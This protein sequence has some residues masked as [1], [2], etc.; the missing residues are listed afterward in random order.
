MSTSIYPPAASSPEELRALLAQ[1][2]RKAAGRSHSTPL[3]SAQQRLWFLDQLEPNSPRYNIPCVARLKGPLQLEPLQEALQTIVNRHESLRA[4]F[5]STEGAPVQIIDEEVR[6]PLHQQEVAGR[7]PEEQQTALERLIHQEVNRPFQLGHERLLRATLLRLHPQEHVLI[8]NMHHIISD[9]WSLKVLFQELATLY[10][11]RVEGRPA[12]LPELPIQYGDYAR[13]QQQWLQ[14]PG[15]ARQLQFWVD[16]LHGHPPTLE[17]PT[18]RPRRSSPRFHG[19]GWWRALGP[20]LSGAL[21]EL[22]GRQRVTLFMVLL[23]GFKALLYRY[24]RQED[25]VVGSPFAGRNRVETEDLI[26]FFVNT[27]PLR[28]RLS[29]ELSFEQLLAQI[30]EVALGAYSH[31]EVPFDKMVEA[32]H[33]ERSLSQTPF[34]NVMFLM[35][36]PLEE[37]GLPQLKLEFIDTGTETSKFDLTLGVQETGEGMIAGVEYSTDLFDQ[38]TMERLLQHYESVLQAMIANPQQRLGEFPL[39]SEQ[40]RRELIINSDLPQEESLRWESVPQWFESQATK[41]P[42]ATAVTYEKSSLTYE[43]LN[44]KA[45]QLARYLRRLGVKAETPVA[46]HLDRSLNLVIAI[47]GVLKAGGAYVPM[48]PAYPKE[49]LKFMLEDTQAPVLL[50]LDSLRATLPDNTARLVCLDSEW[51]KIAAED[52]N[53]LEHEVSRENG[54]Y[55]IYTSGSTGKPKGVVVTHRN[56][57][58]LFEQTEPWY[59]F[60]D[61]DVWTLFHSHT[62]DFSVWELWGAL[63]YGGRLVVVPYL[64]SRSP[65]EFYDLLAEERVTVLNQTPSAFRQLLW[66]EAAKPQ[67]QALNLRYV[68]FGGEALELQSLKP[69]FERHGDEKPRLVNM[70]GITE[71][72]VHV[73]YRIISQ[74]DL[75]SGLGSV[76]GVPIPDLRIYLLDERLEPV[77]PGVPGEICV[78]GSG[79]ARGYLNRPE[80]NSQRFVPDPFS[81]REGTRM[82]RSGDLAKYTASGELEYLGRIDHQVKIRGF[83][84]ELGEIESTLNS[85]PA[86]RESVVLTIDRAGGSKELVA[87]LVPVQETPGIVEIREYLA[88]KIPGYMVPSACVFLEKIPLTHN[89]KVDR[90]ALPAPENDVSAG[91]TCVLPRNE[92]EQ[93]LANIWCE[94]LV[95]KSVG[96]H[97][98]F[99]EL[100]GHSLLATQ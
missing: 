74:K 33:P 21:K 59:G 3:S 10:Q 43:E 83:R 31:G 76:I 37:V 89:G 36:N 39:L 16:Q 51:V 4:R 56:V 47:L 26:G 82:Y 49:R 30:R 8:L 15:F 22:A 71:T 38:A 23:A 61:Q 53:N 18:D 29:P 81:R 93:N 68:I 78:A 86:I 24:T 87:Y 75:D 34:L 85:H 13:W 77:P 63:L 100:G 50:T 70:Y 97:D 99:F 60:D 32:L 66:A 5:V 17:L 91:E 62:F 20:G 98:N 41:T 58:R 79:V 69:W 27:L 42:T 12:Q 35:I 94:L 6:F 7:T 14:S 19:A 67:P 92:T 57:I 55:I 72:T 40:E 95:R 73:T 45:N 46:L 96:I 28:T 11:G 54:A 44:A 65:S 2:L 84:V 1:Y 90:R 88:A 80:L 52:A 64:I 25:L 9:E 48:D